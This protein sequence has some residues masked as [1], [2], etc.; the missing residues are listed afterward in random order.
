MEASEVRAVDGWAT[1]PVSGARQH[2]FKLDGR[3]ACGAFAWLG[4]VFP[5]M[6]DTIPACMICMAVL[7]AERAFK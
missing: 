2:F 5:T 4:A 7:A 3:S 6:G 1:P